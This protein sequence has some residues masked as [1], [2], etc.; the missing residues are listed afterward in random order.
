MH[1]ARLRC[2][3]LLQWGSIAAMGESNALYFA[4]GPED[5]K[6]GLFGRLRYTAN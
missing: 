4:A 5:E 1:T 2:R 3:L 6:D